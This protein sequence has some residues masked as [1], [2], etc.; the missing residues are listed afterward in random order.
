MGGFLH[1]RRQLSLLGHFQHNIAT[2]DQL[3]LDPQL[4]KGRPVGD[5]RQRGADVRVFQNVHIGKGLA[6]LDQG[7]HGAGGKA[8]LRELRGSLHVKEH[9]VFRDLFLDQG[10]YFHLGY[11]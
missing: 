4:G 6:D 3:A 11:L 8:A 7:F 5:A 2:T 9:G 10:F 1:Q